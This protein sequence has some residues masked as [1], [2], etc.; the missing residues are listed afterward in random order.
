MYAARVLQSPDRSMLCQP[1]DGITRAS[2]SPRV[3]VLELKA[4]EQAKQLPVFE[5]VHEFLQ[6]N[7][8]NTAYSV[9]RFGK[10]VYTGK[11][12]LVMHG[13]PGRRALREGEIVSLD[14]GT[15]YQGLQ[16][17]A[18]I[19][20][21]VGRVSAE[22]GALV[23][24]RVTYELMAGYWPTSGAIADDPAVAGL[25]NAIPKIVFSRTLEAAP[26]N[27]TRLI[28]GG[29]EA[30]M[31]RLKEEA[32]RDLFI[33]GSAE[34]AS[35]LTRIGLIDEYRVMVSPVILGSGTP[36]FKGTQLKLKLLRSRTFAIGNVLLVY[37]PQR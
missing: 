19:T 6:E 2:K 1:P 5:R 37:A 27:N 3:R 21:P 26:W 4:G 30:E 24:G 35:E 32:G 25:M 36:L 20:V 18:A 12:D 16:G 34:L 29:L 8:I 23:F 7:E 13:I 17:D 15:I 33:F 14:V 9:K 28:Q 31:R 10:P 11:V 22:A